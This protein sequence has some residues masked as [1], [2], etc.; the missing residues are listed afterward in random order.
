MELK[1]AC[2]AKYIYEIF[3]IIIL[4][5]IIIVLGDL[6]LVWTHNKEVTTS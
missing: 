4:L 3:N 5:A 1:I 2:K 6:A